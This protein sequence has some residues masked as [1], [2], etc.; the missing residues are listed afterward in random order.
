[1]PPFSQVFGRHFSVLRS[2][3]PVCFLDNHNWFYNA[4][5][6]EYAPLFR[7]LATV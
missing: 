5:V 3:V 6:A 2:S 7:C 1:M 4:N